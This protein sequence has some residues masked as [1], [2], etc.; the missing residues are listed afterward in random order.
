M[1]VPRSMTKN[2]RIRHSIHEPRI[3][4]KI[5][6]LI[7]EIFLQPTVHL[8]IVDISPYIYILLQ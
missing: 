1:Y 3:T 8:I 2:R 4:V 7:S 6:L 5:N